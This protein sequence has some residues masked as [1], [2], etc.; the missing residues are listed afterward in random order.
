M[1]RFAKRVG[2]CLGVDIQQKWR[3]E[4]SRLCDDKSKRQ[5]QIQGQETQWELENQKS[6]SGITRTQN[7]FE[8]LANCKDLHQSFVS[9]SCAFYIVQKYGSALMND[10]WS[11]TTSATR[12]TFGSGGQGSLGVPC[13]IHWWAKT[14]DLSSGT[15]PMPV[16]QVVHGVTQ[17]TWSREVLCGRSKEPF[18]LSHDGPVVL[19]RG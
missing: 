12:Y 15:P 11:W 8:W 1:S 6:K 7:V 9:S 2:L 16:H 18:Y 17:V 4:Q 10:S 19:P 5:V 3:V 13:R 14:H